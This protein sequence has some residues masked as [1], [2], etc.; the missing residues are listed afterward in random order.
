MT[1]NSLNLTYFRDRDRFLEQ[2]PVSSAFFHRT[3]EPR[4]EEAR[5]LH[6]RVAY[7]HIPRLAPGRMFLSLTPR[8]CGGTC[9]VDFYIA[10]VVYAG[11]RVDRD[12]YFDRHIERDPLPWIG[13]GA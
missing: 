4:Y 1:D 12:G 11:F 5:E 3:I 6:R 9:Y 8:N 10:V 13:H 7:E 2:S